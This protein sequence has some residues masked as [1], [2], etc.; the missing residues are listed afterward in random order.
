MEQRTRHSALQA[1]IDSRASLAKKIEVWRMQG[2]KIVFTNGCFDILHRGHVDYLTR[3]ADLGNVL[4][5]GVNSD[6][7]VRQLGK[8]AARP[9]QDEQSRLY[10]VAALAVVES[11]T[12]FDEPTPLELIN[13]IRPDVLV[14]GADY[15]AEEQN[16]ASPKYIVGSAEVKAR[17]GTVKTIPLLEGFSTTAIERKIK[18]G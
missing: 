14:K 1:K 15:D 10:I 8:N 5:V 3:A 11:V 2:R 17:G 16:T 4:I 9:I 12:L 18:N 13:F 7:S 6:S